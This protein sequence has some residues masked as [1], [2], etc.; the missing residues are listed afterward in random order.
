MWVC[1]VKFE[2]SFG[3]HFAERGCGGIRS[4]IKWSSPPSYRMGEVVALPL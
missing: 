3:I 4:G 2:Q 1:K